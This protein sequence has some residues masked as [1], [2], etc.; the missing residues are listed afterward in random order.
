MFHHVL[1]LLDF[2]EESVIDSR[3]MI[4]SDFVDME[5]IKKDKFVAHNMCPFFPG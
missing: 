4:I 5:I 2:I 1:L 3:K